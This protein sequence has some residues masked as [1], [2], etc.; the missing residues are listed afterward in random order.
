MVAG[1]PPSRTD[2]VCLFQPYEWRGLRQT[3]ACVLR[4]DACLA[5]FRHMTG[6]LSIG[7]AWPPFIV[8]RR[9]SF[10]LQYSW[11]RNSILSQG[12]STDL[13]GMSSDDP[14]LFYG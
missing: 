4:L 6:Q 7:E 8:T 3:R 1:F 9:R 5:S 12:G 13:K 11:L 2:N 14:S 10:S